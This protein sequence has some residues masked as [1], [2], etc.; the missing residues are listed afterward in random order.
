MGKL[1]KK[2][3]EGASR[4]YTTRNRALK[5]LQVTLADFR[6]LC[7]LKGIYP[8]E[9]HSRKR[10]NRGSTKLTTFYYTK[11]IQLLV[12]EPLILKFRQH[13]VF[14]RKLQRALGKLDYTRAQT[15]DANRPEYT[16]N[17]LVIERYPAFADAL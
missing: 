5:K 11:D 13:K 14:L 8:V 3:S 7:I 15:L 1:K 12:S 10:A 16:L 2:Y 6:R 17:H 4:T 9:P